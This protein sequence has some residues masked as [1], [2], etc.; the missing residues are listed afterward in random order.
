MK[1]NL[2]Y[3]NKNIF[4]IL[5]LLVYTFF[6][7]VENFEKPRRYS[8]KILSY[9]YPIKISNFKNE[10]LVDQNLYNFRNKINSIFIR[11]GWKSKNYLIDLTGRAPGIKLLIDAKFLSEPWWGAGYIG[12][13]NKARKLIKI[14]NYNKVREAWLITTDSETRISKDVLS[15]V[16]LNLERDYEMVGFANDLSRNYFVWKPKLVD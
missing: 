8:G 13:N 10:I 12:S 4:M 3:I 7:L 2:S 1:I 16:G 9:S 6:N 5:I 15:E 11:N 14:T